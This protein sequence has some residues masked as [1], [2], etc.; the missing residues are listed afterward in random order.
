MGKIIIKRDDGFLANIV[1]FTIVIDDEVFDK[2]K[3]R[4][5]NRTSFKKWKSYNFY[6]KFK[7]KKQR[8]N[9]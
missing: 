2:I 1:P 8:S 3:N 4:K 9:I 7:W 5:Y 6:K